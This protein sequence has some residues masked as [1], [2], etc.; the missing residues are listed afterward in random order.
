MDK[1]KICPYCGAHNPPNILDCKKCDSDL[2]NVKVTDETMDQSNSETRE[3][4]GTGPVMVR[5]CDCGEHNPANARKCQ[6]CGEDISVITP[7]PESS[8]TDEIIHHVLS[9]VDGTYAYEVKAPYVLIGREEEMKEY[10]LS[11]SYVSRKHAELFLEAGKLFVRNV[12]QTNYTFVNNKKIPD[13]KVE[14]ADGDELGLGGN[15]MNGERQ[16][17]AAYFL[18]RIGQC[19]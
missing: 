2:S 12:S 18:V 11:K 10:L 6:R 19:I 5:I 17:D 3:H 1:Y 4:P 16:A 8:G 14:L 15:I 13:E 9:S 7:V